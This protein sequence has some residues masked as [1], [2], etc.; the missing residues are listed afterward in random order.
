MEEQLI[1]LE[2]AKFAKECGFNEIVDIIYVI[3]TTGF[4]KEQSYGKPY[5]RGD[6][7][8]ARPTQSFLQKWLR[9]KH[10][11]HVNLEYWT[12]QPI[13]NDVWESCYRPTVNCKTVNLTVY[14]TY[15]EAL[16]I[17]LQTG[18]KLI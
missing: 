6:I 12:N 11:I 4:I 16:E 10:K 14:K 2:T 8:I 7:T 5:R 18:L 3:S 17:G 15:E 9:E 13:G 1:S